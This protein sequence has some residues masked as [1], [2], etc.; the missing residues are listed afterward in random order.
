MRE[1]IARLVCLAAT[2]LVVVLAHVFAVR[3]NPGAE[4]VTLPP[5]PITEAV[6]PPP[7][8]DAGRGRELFAVEGC[9]SCHA[10]A[11][12]GNPRHPLDGVGARR[13]PEQLRAGITGT[14]AAAVP[15]TPAVVRRKLRYRALAPA[16]LEA[17]TAYLLTLTEP[18]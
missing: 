2:A 10:I 8:A 17:L 7:A 12:V 9:A 3:H 6:A 4:P 1:I 18:R 5:G 16:D 14:D 11:G 13:G 15:F